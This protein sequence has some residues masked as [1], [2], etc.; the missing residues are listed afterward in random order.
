MM[1]PLSTIGLVG[2]IVQFVDFGSKL[3]SKSVEL[4][5]STEGALD[6]NLD[7]ETATNHLKD[8]NEK[9]KNGAKAT[10]DTTLK[11]LCEACDKVA[12]E[13]LE[14]LGKVKVKG[15]HEKWKSIRK[16]LRSV[17]S[18][19]H[20]E[21]LEQRLARLRAELNLHLVVDLRCVCVCVCLFLR[22]WTLRFLLF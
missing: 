17:W 4:Y 21:E 6:E 22:F 7:T 3:I 2:N 13:L 1:D 18:K 15:K 11:D 8:L 10:G 19:E 14:A 5:R 16:A 9:L 20:I 12:R